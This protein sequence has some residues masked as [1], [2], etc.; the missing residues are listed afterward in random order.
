MLDVTTLYVEEVELGQFGD[1]RSWSEVIG[2]YLLRE[3]ELRIV[4]VVLRAQFC[5]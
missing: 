4:D 3:S 2:H 1:V 5:N